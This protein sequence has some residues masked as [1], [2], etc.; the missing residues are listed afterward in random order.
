MLQKRTIIFTITIIYTILILYFIFFGF[1][2][3][4]AVGGTTGYTFIFLPDTFYKMPSISDV[5]HLTLMDLV[6]FGNFVAFIP[7]GLLIPLLYRV[8]FIRFFP[9][10]FLSILVIET[11][12]ALTLLGSFDM[13]DAIQNSLGAAIGFGAYKL[14]IRTKNIWA[15]RALIG[16]YCLVLFIGL[17][18][19]FG[20]VDKALTK[21]E[22]PFVAINELTDS[23]GNT[24]IGTKLYSFK[25]SGQDIEPKYNM[26]GVEG[27]KRETYTFTSKN[28]L[29]FSLYYGIPDHMDVEGRIRIFIDGREVLSS[30]GKDQRS[31]PELFPQMFEMP[32]EPV[33]RITIIMEGNEKIW[34]V[35][36]REMK[37]FWN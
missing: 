15:N 32:I 30:S 14:G 16:I 26:F 17:W 10:F 2:R 34:D 19:F 25:V 24:T 9:W 6:D 13:N 21:E 37:Y 31:Y 11:I 5:L 35:G 22:G 27:E 1:G 8:K 36:F 3:I 33:S 18:G 4:D 20:M 7:F 28:Q 12:Q 23:T 29:V